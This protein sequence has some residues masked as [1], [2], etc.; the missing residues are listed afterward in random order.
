[1]EPLDSFITNSVK[2]LEANPSETILSVTYNCKGKGSKV[3]FKTHNASLSTRY[4]FSTRKSK[5]VSRLLSALGPR[6]VSITNGKVE[7]NKTG[8]K[9]KDVGGMSTL[10]ALSLIHI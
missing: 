4:K 7:K 1:M 8:K 10:L 2:L 3:A 5:D 9:T 6:G